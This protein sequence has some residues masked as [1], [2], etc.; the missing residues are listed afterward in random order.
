[1]RGRTKTKLGLFPLPWMI[2][3]LEVSGLLDLDEK[4]IQHNVVDKLTRTSA[5]D[6]D[7]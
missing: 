4:F 5:Y 7:D 3:N 1:M 6:E 2:G